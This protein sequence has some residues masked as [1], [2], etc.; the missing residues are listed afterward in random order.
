MAFNFRGTGVALVT[1]FH[2]DGSIDFDSYSKLINNLIDNGVDYVVPLGTTGESATLRKEEKK[3]I[4]KAALTA[5]NGRIPLVAGVG[6]NDTQEVIDTLKSVD[7][8]GFSAILSVSPYYNKPTQEGIYQHYKA[9]AA[10]SPLPII[11]YNVPGRTGS[12]MTA[13]TTLRLAQLPNIAAIKE[14]SA[15]LDQMMQIIKNKPKDF[16]VISGDDAITLPLIALGAE[17]VISVV[18]NAYPKDFSSMVNACLAGTF[19]EAAPLHYKLVDLITL[20]FADG[21]PGGI[22]AALAIKGI[23]KENM[24]LPLVP[25]NAEVRK[26]LEAEIKRIS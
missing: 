4:F 6:G 5:V 15:N 12:N 16:V 26:A 24:R 20:L 21:N 13:A 14:A 11:L 2:V 17:G 25:V 18:A 23:G 19:A 8:T 10:V 22:K 1:P 9:I 3:A 7:L